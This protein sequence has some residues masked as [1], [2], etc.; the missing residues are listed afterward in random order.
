MYYLVGIDIGTTHTKAVTADSRG[1]IH[2]T[3]TKGYP[4]RQPL[5]GYHEQDPEEIM[6]AV[7]EVLIQ[8]ID[9][10]EQ[11][12]QLKGICFSAAMHSLLAV[13]EVGEPLTA[14]MTW[15]DSRSADIAKKLK[16]STQGEVIYRLTGTPIHAMSPLCKIAW[17]REHEPDIF[18]KAKRFISIKEFIWHRLFGE[19]VIDHSIA[20]ATGLFDI[21]E[22]RFCKEALAFAGIGPER[23]SEP[24]PITYQKAGR[25]SK[26]TI[27]GLDSNAAFII[28]ASDGALAT[29]GSGALH[30]GDAA[31]TIGTSGAIRVLSTHIK[32]DPGQRLFHYAFDER[33]FLTGGAIN[34]GGIVLQWFL[35]GFDREGMGIEWWM[36]KAA[37]VPAGSAGLLF[38]PYVYG[39]RSPVWDASAKGA[40][41]GIT[42]IH[43]RDYFF[44]AILEGVA[45]SLRQV[46][47]AIEESG[48]KIETIY[49]GGG[50]IASP[51]WIRV[52][53]DIL[54]KRI[55]ISRTGDPSA[56]GA[57]F[58]AQKALGII[59]GYG[60][61]TKDSSWDHEFT[62]SVEFSQVYEHNY[63]IFETLYKRLH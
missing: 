44:R 4:S 62:P 49:A 24:V 33:L 16:D 9:S 56:K 53:A 10:I 23:L 42:P 27:A 6:R 43:D 13:D 32:P 15:A 58:L 5:A 7:W 46:M 1:N 26:Q 52:L 51:L 40:Y 36:S 59:E 8:A 38:L 3:F 55:R 61:V 11:K 34:N 47:E 54:Q 41:I 35:D 31:L 30:E 57:I 50:F 12:D 18:S 21:T 14:L 20:A 45:F 60:E 28:G 2:A 37:T 25:L 22:R 29:L 17:L 63:A 19:Y 39:E 48:H